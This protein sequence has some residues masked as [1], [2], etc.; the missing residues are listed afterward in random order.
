MA[1]HCFPWT[2][3]LRGSYTCVLSVLCVWVL[4]GIW[5]HSVWTCLVNR[6][7]ASR[8]MFSCIVHVACSVS[9]NAVTSVHYRLFACGAGSAELEASKTFNT[10]QP[11]ELIQ[12][13]T[14]FTFLFHLHT[15]LHTL[16]SWSFSQWKRYVRLV[17]PHLFCSF[18]LGSYTSVLSVLCV[19]VLSGIWMHSV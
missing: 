17:V 11:V 8:G 9:A 19:W 18:W 16:Q 1:W 15:E 10:S 13:R 7:R 14:H 6:S 5:M 2:V 12:A 3:T 4:S